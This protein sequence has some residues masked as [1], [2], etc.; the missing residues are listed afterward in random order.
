[1][2]ECARPVVPVLSLEIV[3]PV[4]TLHTIRNIRTGQ[5]RLTKRKLR[6]SRTLR[7]VSQS[8]FLTLQK[9]AGW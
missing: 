8:A 2:F 6:F 5:R 4:P 9:M 3:P 1:M 7:P